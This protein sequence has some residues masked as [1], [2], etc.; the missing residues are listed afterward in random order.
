MVDQQ[1]IFAEKLDQVTDLLKEQGIDAWLLFLREKA[2]G[3]DPALR[4]FA[5]FELGWE[6]GLVVDACC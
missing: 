4:L 2:M 3:G 6:S 1:A 5:T